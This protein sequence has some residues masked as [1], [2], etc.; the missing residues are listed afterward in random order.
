METHI[1]VHEWSATEEVK[2]PGRDQCLGIRP[3]VV[4]C[5][6]S[7]IGLWILFL[8]AFKN[9]YYNEHVTIVAIVGPVFGVMLLHIR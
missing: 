2:H 3:P 5:L 4:R 6:L 8:N 9:I 1:I 7:V